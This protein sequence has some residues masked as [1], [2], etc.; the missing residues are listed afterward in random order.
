[1][2]GAVNGVP[3][4]LRA[5][6]GFNGLEAQRLAFFPL[7]R[8]VEE[9]QAKHIEIY[10]SLHNAILHKEQPGSPGEAGLAALELANSLIYSHYTWSQVTL[11][12][13][14]QQYADLLSQ[15]RAQEEGCLKK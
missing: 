11:P 4:R 6:V 15:L 12:L 2:P 7:T 5:F 3:T 13:D 1:M 14:R 8:L 9:G 10:R